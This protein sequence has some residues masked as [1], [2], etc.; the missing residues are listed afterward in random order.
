MSLISVNHLNIT[1]ETKAEPVFQDLCLELDSGWKLGITARNGEGKTTLFKALT[2]E[3]PY[4]GTIDADAAFL[5]FPAEISHPQKN[6]ILAVCEGYG[7][8]EIWKLYR[9]L[10]LMGINPRLLEQNYASLSEG[11]KTCFQICCLFAC[12]ADCML[13]DEPTNHLDLFTQSKIQSYLNRKDHFILASHDRALLDACCDHILAFQKDA[14]EIVRGNFSDWLAHRQRRME[15]QKA[16]NERLRHE[17]S[18]LDNSAATSKIWS[19]KVE[20][21]K[22]GKDRSGLKKDKGF[23][24]HK[25]AKMAQRAKNLERQTRRAVEKRKQLLSAVQKTEPLK[26]LTLPFYKEQLVSFQNFTVRYAGQ[27]NFLFAPVSFEIRKG[28]RI[29]LLG[30]NGSGKSTLLQALTESC[31]AFQP[32]KKD[33]GASRTKEKVLI[34]EG[35]MLVSSHLQISYV[36]QTTKEVC[37]ALDD[38]I[39]NRQLDP[40]LFR[41]IL[42]KLGVL[43]EQFQVPLD[44]YSDGQKRKVQL[45]ASL[46]TPAHLYIWDEPLNYLDIESR[47]QIEQVLLDYKP[48]MLFV[49]HDAVFC[50]TVA[51]D[52]VEIKKQTLDRMENR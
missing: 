35:D 46:S 15:N 31:C 52:T 33:L 13:L 11:E 28:E 22:N 14:A 16:E 5:R 36:P 30:R 47:L 9:E 44:Q 24:S 26:M 49:D 21:S 48:T 25:A 4:S 37:G 43:R 38:F 18:Q 50:R 45:A 39:Q 23:V 40:V 1:Y 27:E 29:S 8:E 32:Q 20:A 42:R 51:T 34:M 41:A 6:A 12:E 19:G 7:L 3:I 17:I 10:D 2:G